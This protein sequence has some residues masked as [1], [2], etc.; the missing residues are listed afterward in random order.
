MAYAAPADLRALKALTYCLTTITVAAGYKHDMS[1]AVFRGRN[2]FGDGDP[3]PM[4]SVLEPP[5]APEQ[6]M[7]PAASSL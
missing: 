1:S 6:M 7:A 2:V 3:L 5:T 4:L